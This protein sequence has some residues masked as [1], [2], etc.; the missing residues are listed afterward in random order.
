MG[1]DRQHA[2]ARLRNRGFILDGLRD[3]LPTTGVIL[4]VANG[5]GEHVVHFAKNLPRL[6]FQPSDPD[7][8][9]RLGV[10]AGK[11]HYRMY[12][13]A[14]PWTP[15]IGW[16]N[17]LSRRDYLHHGPHLALEGDSR[18]DEGAPRWVASTDVV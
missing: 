8:D 3:V 6:V 4:E 18:I 9:A 11:G 7:P 15:C 17:R 2:P 13:R 12:V 16:A 5:S 14:L 10:A 1:D